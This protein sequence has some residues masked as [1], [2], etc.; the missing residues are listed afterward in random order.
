MRSRQVKR[1]LSENS[2]STASVLP[3]T[4]TPHR[5]CNIKYDVTVPTTACSD[6]TIFG[7]RAKALCCAHSCV[8]SSRRRHGNRM[9]RI[10]CYEQRTVHCRHIA[11]TLPRLQGKSQSVPAAASRRASC[12]AIRTVQDHAAVESTEG[13]IF[14]PSGSNRTAGFEHAY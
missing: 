10:T 14:Y 8:A 13:S 2:H 11:I 6:S 5:Q 12:V 7:M 9:M 3:A 1:G 4:H